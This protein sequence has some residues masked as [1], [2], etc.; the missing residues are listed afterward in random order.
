M[1]Q[2]ISEPEILRLLGQ[3]ESGAITVAPKSQPQFVY[4]GSVEYETSDGWRLILLN[5]C[6]R[7]DHL[8][9]VIA[10]DG[11][12]I[13]WDAMQEMPRVRDY[14]PTSEIAWKSYGLPGHCRFRCTRCSVGIEYQ[15]DGRFYCRACRA[16]YLVE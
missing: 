2:T 1:P 5:D 6:N 13:G 15:Q 3:I 7:W 9:R 12:E 10:P 8:E 4:A 16:K 14:R 11:R